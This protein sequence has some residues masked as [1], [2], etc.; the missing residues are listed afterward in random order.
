MVFGV[1]YA[2]TDLDEAAKG[3]VKGITA[4]SGKYI[5][6]SNVHTLVTAIENRVYR[7]AL[8]GAAVTFPDGEP[9][10]GRLRARGNARARRI[11]GPDFM[12][13]VLQ[14]TSDGSVK[15]FFYG[16]TKH[17]LKRLVKKI[18]ME[19]P[20]I[21]IVGAVSPPFRNLSEKEDHKVRE[22]I[23]NSGAD[24][25]W[26]GLGAPNQELFMALHAGL[27][28]GVM[29]GVGAAF[30]FL[31]GTKKRAPVLMRK[32]HM[33]WLHR[34]LSE[35]GR[36]VGRYFVTNTKFLWYCLTRRY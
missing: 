19:Y 14:E 35:P 32:L 27:Y 9:V 30:D 4:L 11:A 17:T 1:R 33:E 25:I 8:N 23:N 15:H 21:S 13:K 2:V 34:M 5:C 20:N 10:A 36:L 31:S 26:I 12:K 18:K 28:G 16:S 22:K 29:L 7:K 6:F 24:I 3:F